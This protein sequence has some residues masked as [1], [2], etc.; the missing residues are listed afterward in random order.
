MTAG[1]KPSMPP[2]DS[3][4]SHPL[5]QRAENTQVVKNKAAA[6]GSDCSSA[7]GTIPVGNFFTIVVF[8]NMGAIMMLRSRWLERL[9]NRGPQ[10]PTSS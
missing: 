7:P 5:S 9:I 4:M 3:S 6:A 1:S 10:R 2:C 8:Y